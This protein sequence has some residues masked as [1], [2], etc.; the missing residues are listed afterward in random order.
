MVETAPTLRTERLRLRPW[1]TTDIDELYAILSAPRT[2]EFWPAPFDR[3]QTTAWLERSREMYSVEGYGR[4]AVELAGTGDIIGDCG[5][6]HLE[7][8]GQTEVD[9]GYIIH[10]PYWRNGYAVEAAGAVLQ[11]ALVERGVRRVVAN[12]AEQHAGSRRVAERLGMRLERRFR[13][14]R[15]RDLP[16]L[17]F[18]ADAATLATSRTRPEG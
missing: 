10:H 5:L 4:F 7:F 1:Q 3:D 2:M 6:L 8:E 15:N 11:F 16:T 9:L 12:M 17:F 18:V 14:P 13:N